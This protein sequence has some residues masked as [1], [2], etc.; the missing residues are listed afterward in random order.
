MSWIEEQ[1]RWSIL[2]AYA[3]WRTR[4]QLPPD[5][6]AMLAA[7][8]LKHRHRALLPRRPACDRVGRTL[9]EGPL[10]HVGGLNLGLPLIPIQLQ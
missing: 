10:I 8:G 6:L 9:I 5:M 2:A 3:R 4:Q 1:C 7:L